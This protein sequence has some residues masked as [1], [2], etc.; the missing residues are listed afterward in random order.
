MTV[1]AH[2]PFWLAVHFT[3]PTRILYVEPDHE[4]YRAAAWTVTGPYV[5]AGQL[6][7]AVEEAYAR[8]IAAAMDVIRAHDFPFTERVDLIAERLAPTVTRGQSDG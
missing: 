6:Q 1:I 4:D 5:P 3:E 7:G 8:G 2:D